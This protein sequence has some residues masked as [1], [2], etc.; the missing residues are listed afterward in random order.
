ML[1]ECVDVRDMEHARRYVAPP[2]SCFT[3][4]DRGEACTLWQNGSQPA[5]GFC[6]PSAS[7]S[8]SSRLRATASAAM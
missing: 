4:L 8:A 1:H 6:K 3:A 5:I 7:A 2:Q